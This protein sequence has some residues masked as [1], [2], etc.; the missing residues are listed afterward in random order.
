MRQTWLQLFEVKHAKKELAW[1][2]SEAVSADK[3]A[4]AALKKIKDKSVK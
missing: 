2:M 4:E 1:K 3:I